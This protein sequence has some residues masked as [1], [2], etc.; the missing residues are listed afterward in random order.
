MVSAGLTHVES[1][2]V[3]EMCST[4]DLSLQREMTIVGAVRGEAQHAMHRLTL[5]SG[6]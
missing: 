2:E 5:L 1:Q 3:T 4:D 6:V